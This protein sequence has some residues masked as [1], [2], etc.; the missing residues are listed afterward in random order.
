MNRIHLPQ[1]ENFVVQEAGSIR[2]N[3]SCICAH[4]WGPFELAE[5]INLA[6]LAIF[7][8]ELADK[9]EKDVF[10]AHHWIRDQT[11]MEHT[12]SEIT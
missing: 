9:Y 11:L 3:S 4:P 12:K 7:L 6:D 10:R 2:C 1:R 5:T 8:D